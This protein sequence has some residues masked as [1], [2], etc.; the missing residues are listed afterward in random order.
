[1]ELRA[2][3]VWE[4]M[5]CWLMGSLGVTSV[6]LAVVSPSGNHGD[7]IYLSWT[8]LLT[9]QMIPTSSNTRYNCDFFNSYSYSNQISDVLTWLLTP[10]S[11]SLA[12][13]LKVPQAVRKF[14]SL[15]GTR[16]FVTAFTRNRHVS[17]SWARS[18]QS[19]SPSLFSRI[20]F[21]IF[22]HFHVGLPSDLLHSGFP[23]KT[24]YV[25]LTCYMPCLSQS[26]WFDHPNNISWGVQSM[27][28]LVL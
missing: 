5:W 2:E 12:E 20:N 16:R 18:I 8:Y 26:S 28:L 17:T 21:S 6:P 19:I 11:W 4:K 13:K 15:Y 10:W 27:K 22:S 3:W 7:H 24:L 9:V 1:L 23:I 25:Y 14:P